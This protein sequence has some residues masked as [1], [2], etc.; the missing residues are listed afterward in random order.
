VLYLDII[1]IF[2][3]VLQLLGD[4]RRGAIIAVQP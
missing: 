4:R 3:F 2:L 1:N